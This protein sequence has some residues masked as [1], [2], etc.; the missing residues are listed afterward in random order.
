[1]CGATRR[2]VPCAAYFFGKAGWNRSGGILHPLRVKTCDGTVMLPAMTTT[3]WRKNM[4]AKFRKL[5]ADLCELKGIKDVE[6][7]IHGAPIA[8]NGVSIS[9]IYNELIRKDIV[10]MFTDFGDVPE[11]NEA[12]IYKALLKQNHIGYSGNGPGFCMSPSTGRVG[13]VQN[14]RIDELTV[15][16]LASTLVF[17]AGKALEWRNSFFLEQPAPGARRPHFLPQV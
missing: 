17:F 6:F 1:M 8:V 10:F 3:E 5:V 12:K 7:I 9:L 11:E 13:Y 4:K 14:L 2:R 16:K 15:D